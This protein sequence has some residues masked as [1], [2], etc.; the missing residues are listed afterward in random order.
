MQHLTGIAEHRC[1]DSY[2]R[3]VDLLAGLEPRFLEEQQFC[4]SDDNVDGEITLQ[5]HLPTHAVFCTVIDDPKGGELKLEINIFE[6]K[7]RS[8]AMAGILN[9]NDTEEA[10][11]FLNKHLGK[12]LPVTINDR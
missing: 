6:R 4:V 11:I 10:L 7:D 1:K 2:N 8:A 9:T 3:A 5:W 12:I